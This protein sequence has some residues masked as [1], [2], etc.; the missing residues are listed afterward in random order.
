MIA[1]IILFFFV[2]FCLLM[3]LY[4]WGL[5]NSDIVDD[6]NSYRYKTPE[7]ISE[8]VKSGDKER[9]ASIL[10]KEWADYQLYIATKMED[11]LEKSNNDN[12]D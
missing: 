6:V 8:I 11:L 2:S 10:C 1:N 5:Y 3:S 12:K 9:F 7:E 4:I